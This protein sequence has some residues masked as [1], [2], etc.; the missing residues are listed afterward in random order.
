[1]TERM[2]FTTRGPIP[3]DLGDDEVF[4][5][6]GAIPADE[7]ATL[8]DMQEGL[9]AEGMSTQQQ[10]EGI[11][12]ILSNVMLAESWERFA[13]RLGDR[14]RPVS[15]PLLLEITNW[16]ASEWGKGRALPPAPSI[17]TPESGGM[18]TT[19]G[20]PAEDSTLTGPETVEISVV[21]DTST[22]SGT[23]SPVA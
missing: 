4:M 23:G 11:K 6:I 12:S 2:S 16:L 8:L 13:P 15:F 5:V 20:V 3:F 10:L 21:P 1:M 7:F 14:S 19:D 17:P 18:T 22:E 9:S